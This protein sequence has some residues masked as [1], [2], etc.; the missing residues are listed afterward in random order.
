[1]QTTSAP[2][3]PIAQPAA[4]GV[5]SIT[6]P[7]PLNPITAIEVKET[8]PQAARPS[9]EEIAKAAYLLW[10]KG[11]GDEK[12]NWLEAERALLSAQVRS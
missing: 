7:G 2:R 12:L 11:G 6:R 4:N 3:K 1:M 8:K 5:T 9:H 10:L